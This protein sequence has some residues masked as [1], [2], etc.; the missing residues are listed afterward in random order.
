MKELK[1]PRKLISSSISEKTELTTLMYS[2]RANDLT[3]L[4]RTAL[5]SSE[6]DN[7]RRLY[8]AHETAHNTTDL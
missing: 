5:F 6:N 7:Y 4:H 8:G 2:I 3:G 1:G